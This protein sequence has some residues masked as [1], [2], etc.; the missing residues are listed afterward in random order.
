MPGSAPKPS[1]QNIPGAQLEADGHGEQHQPH[2][3]MGHGCTTTKH[4]R[5]WGTLPTARKIK[6]NSNV[7]C[8]H[9]PGAQAS[10]PDRVS[11]CWPRGHTVLAQQTPTH[12]AGRNSSDIKVCWGTPGKKKYPSLVWMLM[13]SFTCMDADGFKIKIKC[14]PYMVLF[15]RFSNLFS[16]T[17]KVRNP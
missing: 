3:T 2:S 12:G 10:V 6:L 8:W 15:Q 4:T 14:I 17:V 1:S 9:I 7:T 11:M 5:G 13:I 16:S